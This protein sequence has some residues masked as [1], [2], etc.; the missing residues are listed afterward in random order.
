MLTLICLICFQ[1]TKL[2]TYGEF[3]QKLKLGEH[4][5]YYIVNSFIF[6]FIIALL[7]SKNTDFEGGVLVMGSLYV[8]NT[9][10]LRP[11]SR[12]VYNVFVSTMA[13]ELLLILGIGYFYQN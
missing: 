3:R 12:L 9:M 4:Y 6:K 10:I 8:L 2:K 13:I 1:A 7:L 5:S 11:F